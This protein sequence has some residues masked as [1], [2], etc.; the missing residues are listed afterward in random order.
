MWVQCKY[1]TTLA[2]KLVKDGN[3][4]AV[5]LPS[6][7]LAMSGLQDDVLL[8]VKKGQ[9]IIRPLVNNRQNWEQLIAQEISKNPRALDADPELDDW[10]VT[11]NDGFN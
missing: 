6:T 3:S 2:T 4:K 7:V 5:R 9:I 1:M 8:E 10:D 11:I